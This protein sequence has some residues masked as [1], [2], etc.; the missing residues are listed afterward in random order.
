M[1]IS[2]ETDET[3]QNWEYRLRGTILLNLDGDSEKVTPQSLFLLFSGIMQ[4]QVNTA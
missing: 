4:N 3:E 1:P 2:R